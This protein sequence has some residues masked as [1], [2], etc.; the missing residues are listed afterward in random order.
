MRLKKNHII[1]TCVTVLLFLAIITLICY[2]HAHRIF[3]PH[4]EQELKELVDFLKQE[5]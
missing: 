3:H 5:K 1:I 4:P 2:R